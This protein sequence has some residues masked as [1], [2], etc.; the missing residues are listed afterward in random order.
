MCVPVAELAAGEFI[1]EATAARANQE[2]RHRQIPPKT[3]DP[4]GQLQPA[5]EGQSAGLSL[6]GY[7]GVAS[8]TDPAPVTATTARGKENQLG[9]YAT[10]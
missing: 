2:N 1:G 10:G 6:A 4:T 3:K 7:S 8:P 5:H 9:P